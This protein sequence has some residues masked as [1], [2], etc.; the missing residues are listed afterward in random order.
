MMP[1]V[2]VLGDYSPNMGSFGKST[3]A[4]V[5]DSTGFNFGGGQHIDNHSSHDFAVYVF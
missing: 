2:Q 4:P 5:L 3:S 1:A